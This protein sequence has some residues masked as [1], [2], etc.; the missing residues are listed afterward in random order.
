[1]NPN[2]VK[3]LLESLTAEFA[4]PVA[5]NCGPL[6]ISEDDTKVPRERLKDIAKQWM[7]LDRGEYDDIPQ[8]VQEARESIGI[9][10]KH[11]SYRTSVGITVSDI[12]VEIE[13]LALETSH[14][15]QVRKVLESLIKEQGL[16]FKIFNR[17]FS[18]IILPEDPIQYRN[19]EMIELETLLEKENLNVRVRHSG[20]SLNRMDDREYDKP[21]ISFSQVQEMTKFL[22]S[23]LEK[24]DLKVCLLHEGFVLEKKREFEIHVSETKELA[25]RLSIMT[26]INYRGGSGYGMQLSVDE[27][28]P[29]WTNAINWKIVR[30][31]ASGPYY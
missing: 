13:R 6:L 18:V 21:D 9:Y 27:I 3:K 23:A 30:V 20:F 19:K 22:Q 24:H 10:K 12:C 26:G 11:R 1:M 16:P 31:S 15:P 25:I 7:D 4:L 14:V 8:E 28:P 5:S 29:G 17:A 2:D